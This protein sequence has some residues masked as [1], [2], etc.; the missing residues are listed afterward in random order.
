M[1]VLVICL[2]FLFYF[3]ILVMGVRTWVLLILILMDI[4]MKNVKSHIQTK[5]N[6]CTIHLRV[7]ILCLLNEKYE[8]I[9]DEIWQ[10]DMLNRIP[11]YY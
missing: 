8:Q 1:T 4:S 7:Y 10:E 5:H 6:T 9:N 11:F 2:Y 3:V